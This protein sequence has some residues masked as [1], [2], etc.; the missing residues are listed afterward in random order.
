LSCRSR[1]AISGQVNESY[2][3]LSTTMLVFQLRSP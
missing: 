2:A 1:F 3:D